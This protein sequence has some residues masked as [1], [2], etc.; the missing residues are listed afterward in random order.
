MKPRNRGLSAEI[1]LGA[2][3]DVYTPSTSSGG[4]GASRINPSS[5]SYSSSAGSTP[6]SRG[7]GFIRSRFSAYANT[8]RTICSVVW[9]TSCTAP[10]LYSIGTTTGGVLYPPTRTRLATVWSVGADA[11]KPTVSPGNTV[12]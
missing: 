11:A 10:H 2:I 5:R 8:L 1:T 3:T 12:T 7:T 6:L 4:R 9:S